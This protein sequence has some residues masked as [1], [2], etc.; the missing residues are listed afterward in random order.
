MN[1]T[2]QKATAPIEKSEEVIAAS[3]SH[4]AHFLPTAPFCVK[5]KV[6]HVPFVRRHNA[7]EN[8]EGLQQ[9]FE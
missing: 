8:R 6:P 7:I 3:I 4:R 1:E 2:F 5:R 9:R